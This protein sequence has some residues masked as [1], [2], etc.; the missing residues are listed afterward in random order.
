MIRAAT[1]DDLAALY[2]L[3]ELCFAERRFRK[4]HLVWILRNPRAATYVFEEGGVVGALM[5]MS[6][7]GVTRVLSV[8]VHPD[9]RRQGI[10]QRLMAVAEEFARRSDAVEIRLEVNT[11]NTGALAF[12]R[13]LGYDIIARLP[14]YY[15]W[16]DDAYGMTK[17]LASTPTEKP[18]R[19]NLH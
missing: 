5:L 9:R 7:P 4:E 10:G 16:G 11:N 3:E 8:G 13:E 2:E 12:Y 19:A 18:L 6:E 14:G 15:S 1:P 17:S